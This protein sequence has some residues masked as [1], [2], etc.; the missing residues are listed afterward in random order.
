MR[1]TLW[2]TSS[3]LPC[4]CA[5]PGPI[6]ATTVFRPPSVRRGHRPSYD[7]RDL[8]GSR[9]SQDMTNDST[10]YSKSISRR[11]D[12]PWQS[13]VHQVYCV[14]LPLMPSAHLALTPRHSNPSLDARARHQYR[15]FLKSAAPNPRHRCSPALP[16]MT[17]KATPSTDHIHALV[18]HRVLGSPHET[19]PGS[20]ILTPAQG[21]SAATS[22]PLQHRAEPRGKP[23]R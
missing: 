6:L 4:R 22:K 20:R 14:C 10:E 9:K 18:Q 7:D 17:T 12:P 23:N 16:I 13:L 3:R 21:L 15:V 8:H 19:T 5:S 1:C 2:A 11:Q